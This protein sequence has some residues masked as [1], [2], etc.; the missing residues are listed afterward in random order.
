M[1]TYMLFIHPV[2]R[3]IS[4]LRIQEPVHAIITFKT[5]TQLAWFI[6]GYI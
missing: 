4:V 6:E 3:D 5:E 1:N 2:T